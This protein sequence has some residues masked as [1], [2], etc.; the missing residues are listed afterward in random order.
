MRIGADRSGLTI[1]LVAPAASVHTAR[2][3]AM[4]A[5]SGHRV[6]VASWHP[7]PGLPGADLRIAPRTG[8]WPGWRAA[9]A[10][11]WLRRLI[12]EVRP[13]VVHVHSLGAHG[14]LAMALP[15]GTTLV[16]TPWGSELRAASHSALRA[17][18]IRL[19]V[20]RADP[21][22]PTSAEVA[23]E[24]TGRYRVPPARIQ[25]LSWGVAPDLMSAL[26]RISA[27]AVRSQF[28][29]P[30]EATV[31]IS[32]RSTSAAYRTLEIVSAFARAAMHR[33]DL[34]LLVLTGHCPD[35]E[36]ARRAK[37]RYLDAVRAAT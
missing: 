24:L 14:L 32:I 8:T 31:V 7:G 33:P 35:R 16:A 20:R 1:V 3:A 36:S 34:F 22:L 27:A 6:V 29:V 11:G 23:A 2:W 18:I 30:A 28:G 26:P 15:G 13:D 9:V 10:A 12:R 19:A 25:V 17:A 5:G 37:D 4:L 21:V